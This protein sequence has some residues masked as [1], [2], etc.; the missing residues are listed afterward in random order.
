MLGCCTGIIAFHLC[1]G[2]DDD[3][4]STGGAVVVVH[5]HLLRQGIL[6]VMV[7]VMMVVAWMV[8]RH[9]CPDD[10]RHHRYRTRFALCTG[11][12]STEFGTLRASCF[13]K[14]RSRQ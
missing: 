9:G 14:S 1:N 3:D 7:E 8:S 6:V 4:D 2:V 5:F 11:V 12:T 13:Y 10:L